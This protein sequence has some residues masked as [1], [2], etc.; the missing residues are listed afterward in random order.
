[1]AGESAHE[2]GRI[3]V[4]KAKQWLNMTTRVANAWTHLDTPM[5]ELLEFEWPHGKHQAF[6]FDIGGRFRGGKV[7]G[8]S[9]LAEVKNYANEST[10][11]AQYREF[12]AKCYVALDRHPQRCDHFLWI[13]WAP[14]RAANWDQHRSVES[15]RNALV[16]PNVIERCFGH[17]DTDLALASLDPEKLVKVSK[18]IWLITM[19]DREEHLTLTREHFAEVIRS[20]ELE[21]G[22]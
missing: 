12:L 9:F 18:S 15:V 22:S 16:E 3:G 13:S 20:I 19:N 17:A 6:S 2:K 10:L 21:A 1:M 8:Q 7:D 5:A 14:F 11:P 4:A